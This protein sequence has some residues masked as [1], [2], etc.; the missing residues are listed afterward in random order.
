MIIRVIDLETTGFDAKEEV[1]ELAGVDLDTDTG[2]VR[3]GFSELVRPTKTIP[4]E[5]SAVHHLVDEDLVSARSWPEVWPACFNVEAVAFA[6]HNASF[7]AQWITDEMLKGR[8][9]ICTWKA[10]LRIWP[11]ARSHSNQ[12]LRY[13]L[14]PVGLDFDA[15]GQRLPQVGDAHR[16]EADAIVT[17]FTLRE[18]MATGATLEQMIA[19]TKVPALLPTVTFGKH[20]GTAWAEVPISYLSWVVSKSDMGEDVLHTARH[21]LRAGQEIRQ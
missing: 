10:A 8:P 9:L 20:R 11:G 7:E 18:L 3:K 14:R 17:A 16:A 15:E 5:A 4:P 1:V 19:W 13:Q 21:H 12:A 6:A 2:A